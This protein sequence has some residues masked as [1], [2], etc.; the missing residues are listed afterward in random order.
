LENSIF[1]LLELDYYLDYIII[2]YYYMCYIL[3]YYIYII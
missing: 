1:G 2:I 3:L